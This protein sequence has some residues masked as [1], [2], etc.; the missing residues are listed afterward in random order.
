MS[1]EL[2]KIVGAVLLACLIAMLAGFAS[3][4][5][6]HPKKLEQSVYTVTPSEGGATAAAGPTGPADIAPLLASADVDAGQKAT[7]ACA[8]CHTFN[9][10]GAN[11][12]G[13]NLY[14]IVNNKT[15]HVD[16]FAYSDAMKTKAG[17]WT[18]DELNHFLYSPKA[19]LP[20]TKMA[21]A[22]MKK[23]QERANVIAYLRS[24]AA[25]PAPLPQ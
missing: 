7:R 14:G 11:K 25:D 9:E 13:P 3:D 6:V 5:L 19:H 18:Y 21:Y 12:V 22:G 20:G 2:N 16:G 24:L 1:M 8:A 4:V 17:Q 15:A 10:G 23:D